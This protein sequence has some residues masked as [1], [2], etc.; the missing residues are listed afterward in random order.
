M[1]GGWPLCCTVRRGEPAP[2][3]R[4][5]PH[6]AGEVPRAFPAEQAAQAAMQ[7]GGD[8]RKRREEVC[9]HVRGKSRL[10]Q[11]FVIRLETVLTSAAF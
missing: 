10:G 4:W 7:S 1:A 6:A 8:I 3:D 11:K 2:R 5:L 9:R